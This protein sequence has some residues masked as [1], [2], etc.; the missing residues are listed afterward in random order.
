MEEVKRYVCKLATNGYEAGA[1]VFLTE[2]EVAN[3]NGG[4]AEPRF[5]LAEDQ[6]APEAPAATTTAGS[7]GTPNVYKF[8][9]DHGD[10]KAG[11]TITMAE[12]SDEAALKGLILD[13]IVEEVPAQQ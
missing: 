6:G 11:D 7:T 5:V 1:E 8:L 2:A 3:A 4:E 12:L 10:M 9:K 13:G